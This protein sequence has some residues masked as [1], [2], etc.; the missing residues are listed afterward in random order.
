MPVAVLG[1]G[2]DWYRRA[3][4]RAGLTL[5]LR[6]MRHVSVNTESATLTA[7]GGALVRN[8]VNALPED[9]ALVTGVHTEVGLA[10]LA[11]GGGYGK[12][13]PRFG[14]VTDNLKRAEVVL[15][16][17]ALVTASET[18]NPDLFWSLR[19]AGKN[20]AVLVSADFAI[21]KLSPVLT[22]TVFI[23]PHHAQQGLRSLQDILDEA[24]DRLSIFS[25]FAAHP[26]KGAGLILEPLWTGDEASGEGYIRR[27]L[28][29]PGSE[30]VAKSWSFY[31][32]T[33]NAKADQDSWPKG[34]GYRMDAINLDRLSD[35]TTGAI[36]ECCLRMPAGQNCIMLHDFR[37]KAARVAAD[38]TAFP[39][40]RDHFNMQIVAGWQTSQEEI[41]GEQWVSDV[42]ERVL[43]FSNQSAY[44]AVT[45]PEGQER[46]RNFYGQSLGKLKRL[47]GYYDAG[48]RFA[49][50]YG[51]D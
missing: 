24:D 46:A 9:Y 32:E 15:G 43:P 42:M 13:N 33:Y 22:A 3:V 49:A 23:Q 10:G 5:D 12:L 2:H 45:G 25:S 31:K 17:G 37:G 36:I 7:S 21:H 6:G 1:G 47:R 51:I 8:A 28:S 39:H 41:S 34:R 35:E 4:S 50:P 44:P 18:E 11:F 19:G 30:L 26:E 29:L 14:L 20:F 38:D 16:N 40:R 27:L 48:N